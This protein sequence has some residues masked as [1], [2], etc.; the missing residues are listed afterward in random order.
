MSTA[1]K[2]VTSN[3]TKLLP[4]CA[5]DLGMTMDELLLN[6]AQSTITAKKPETVERQTT[7]RVGVMRHALAGLSRREIGRAVGTSAAT[8]QS[9]MEVLGAFVDRHEGV[10]KRAK[11]DKTANRATGTRVA[12]SALNKY[13]QDR[14]AQ[15]WSMVQVLWEHLT[16]ELAEMEGVQTAAVGA[17]DYVAGQAAALEA[18]C[19]KLAWGE[20][21]AWFKAA[22]AAVG[23]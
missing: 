8:V 10:V 22:Q 4:E 3:P 12:G 23:E 16:S 20:A 1:A 18:V 15:A 9:D 2:Y 17:E 13:A 6:L 21:A 14:N 7:R 19:E 5:S 11:V